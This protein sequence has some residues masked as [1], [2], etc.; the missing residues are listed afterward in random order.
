MRRGR[1]GEGPER[2][3]GRGII[4]EVALLTFTSCDY[5]PME[6]WRRRRE[7]SENGEGMKI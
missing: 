4:E 2:G 3:E 6:P 1:R 5:L 7:Q